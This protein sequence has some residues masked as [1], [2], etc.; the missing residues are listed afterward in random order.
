[1]CSFRNV[2]GIFGNFEVLYHPW[3]VTVLFHNT[4][5]LENILKTVPLYV[6]VK[7]ASLNPLLGKFKN[8]TLHMFSYATLCLWFCFMR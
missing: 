5:F 4:R 1:M 3:T 8:S 7:R 6:S 2:S